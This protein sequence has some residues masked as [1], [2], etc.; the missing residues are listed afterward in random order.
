V[1]AAVASPQPMATPHSAVD[2]RQSSGIPK[3]ASVTST[4]APPPHPSV[5]VPPYRSS[6]SV[7][8]VAKT[9]PADRPTFNPFEDAPG[10]E[11]LEPS[12]D[13]EP[14]GVIRNAERFSGVVSVDARARLAAEPPPDERRRRSDSDRL[15]CSDPQ[16]RTSLLE[17]YGGQCQMCHRTFPKRD[18]EPY[19]VASHYIEREDGRYLDCVAN[20]ICLCADHFAKWQHAAK[21]FDEESEKRILEID[22]NADDPV[23]RVRLAGID[24]TITYVPAHFAKLQALYREAGPG[25]KAAATEPV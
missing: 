18:G 24:E 16:V 25:Q 3:P 19:F 6:P 10:I 15:E 22:P 8:P 17:Y 11:S 9:E 13:E 7:T 21:F 1:P 23:I 14:R 12:N 20:A 5:S 4:P 2:T